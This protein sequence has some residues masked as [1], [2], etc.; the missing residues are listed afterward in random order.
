VS[1]KHLQEAP[2]DLRVIRPDLD[3]GWHRF[4][5]RLLEKDR[6][7]RFDTAAEVLEALR[8]LPVGVRAVAR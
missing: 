7:F 8:A 3:K 6:S 2:P 5:T 4:V 1:L